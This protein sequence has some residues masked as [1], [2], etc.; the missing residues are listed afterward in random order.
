VAL[1]RGRFMKVLSV[2]GARPQF[3]KLA[4]MAAAFAET[5]DS[6]VIVHT[7]Q[8][9]DAEMSDVFFADMRIPEPDVHLG[10]GSGS[11]R[12]QTGAMLAALAVVLGEHKPDWVLAVAGPNTVVVV[13]LGAATGRRVVAPL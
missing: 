8:H 9:Y 5:G 13:A 2:V 7:G 11:H 10:V 3:V 12:T 4:P 6:H 1:T